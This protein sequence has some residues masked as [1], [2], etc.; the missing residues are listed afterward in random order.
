MHL[1]STTE[2]ENGGYQLSPFPRGDAAPFAAG[3]RTRRRIPRCPSHRL[4]HKDQP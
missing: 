2:Y 3:G 1:R 4:I